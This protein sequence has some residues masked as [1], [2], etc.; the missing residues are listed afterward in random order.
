MA[1]IATQV[2]LGKKLSE[3]NLKTKM[4]PH[5]GVKEAVF[6]FNMFQEVDP[7]LGPEM[8]STGEV[9]GLADS[10]G[11]AFYKAEEAAQQV[12]PGSGTV[13][14][15]VSGQDKSGIIEIAR[16]L[17]K[18][19]FSIKATKG[20]HDY[21]QSQ[22]IETESILKMHE[23]RP[24]IVD[25]IKNGEIQFIINTPSGRLSKY[26]DSYIRKS[27]IKYK[28]PYITTLAAA[29]AAAKGIT[30]LRLGHGR[31]K[32]LQQYHTDIK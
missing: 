25:A 26:D 2:M 30:A 3:L 5:F 4:V 27:A 13:L 21:L 23:G 14:L 11:L 19:G 8:R 7:L 24:N 10:F 29:V 15:T 12:L 32:S 20:T 17:K 6:P 31:A 1:R 22:G 9:L 18:L 28:I 16:E